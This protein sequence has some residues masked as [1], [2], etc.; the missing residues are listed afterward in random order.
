MDFN[1][2]EKLFNITLSVDTNI[3][4]S[5]KGTVLFIAVLHF[6]VTV[7]SSTMSKTQ[8]TSLTR[9]TVTQSLSHHISLSEF[10]SHFSFYAFKKHRYVTFEVFSIRSIKG[11]GLG[12]PKVFP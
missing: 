10:S 3:I 6:T 2:H 8:A 12:N 9:S 11:V 7:V 5:S 1:G 4:N